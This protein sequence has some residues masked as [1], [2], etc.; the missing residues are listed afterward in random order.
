M[1]E[2]RFDRKAGF[3]LRERPQQEG[4]EDEQLAVSEILRT[5]SNSP[6]AV[7]DYCLSKTCKF[8]TVCPFALTPC[9]ATVSVLPSVDTLIPLT[10]VRLKDFW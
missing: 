8:L 1:E 3:I 6:R 2:E 10:R 9:C 4:G 7:A 5:F